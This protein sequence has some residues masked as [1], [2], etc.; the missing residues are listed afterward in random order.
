MITALAWSPDSTHIAS[1]SSDG[2]IH[3]WNAH[4][5]QHLGTFVEREAHTTPLMPITA[6]AWSPDEAFLAD[7]TNGMLRI[8]D[9]SGHLQHSITVSPQGTP[10]TALSWVC[11]APHDYCIPLFACDDGKL[12]LCAVASSRYVMVNTGQSGI[13]TP[14]AISWS[15]WKQ[16][17]Y[18][19]DAERT[20]SHLVLHLEQFSFV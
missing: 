17:G 11:D 15:A 19:M 12:A 7:A 8:W 16:Q 1:G 13:R 9:R 10:I 2:S 4:S 6:L 18:L 20:A 5:L 3:L 14:R